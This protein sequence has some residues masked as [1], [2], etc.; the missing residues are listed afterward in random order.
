MTPLTATIALF[1]TQQFSDAIPLAFNQ[2]VL[3]NVSV[4]A[5][6]LAIPMSLRFE[7]YG[8]DAEPCS[9]QIKMRVVG[10]IWHFLAAN[11]AALL[12]ASLG[13]PPSNQMI[14]AASVTLLAMMIALNNILPFIPK[15][16]FA[17]FLWGLATH[18]WIYQ[19]LQSL[20]ELPSILY[21]MLYNVLL[22]L[23]VLAALVI[24]IFV[25]HRLNRFEIFVNYGIQ[26]LSAGMAYVVIYWFSRFL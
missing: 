8:W 9:R 12:L 1:S 4:F 5:A 26:T 14:F 15:I 18:L 3:L 7:P 19:K 22:S 25:V 6:L 23:F 20:G 16:G 10:I 11:I 13:L 21:G 17:V 24:F 2:S